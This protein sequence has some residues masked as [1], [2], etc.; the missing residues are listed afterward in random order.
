MFLA[1]Q[2]V[3]EG[4]LDGLGYRRGQSGVA[5]TPGLR[6]D[7]AP[8]GPV[9]HGLKHFLAL[10][11]PESGIGFGDRGPAPGGEDEV[12]HGTGERDRWISLRQRPQEGAD[13]TGRLGQAFPGAAEFHWYRHQGH[14]EIPQ[15]LIISRLTLR[16]LLTLLTFGGPQLG[17]LWCCFENL[18]NTQWLSHNR[19][20]GDDTLLRLKPRRFLGK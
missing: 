20:L 4:R 12:M 16:P 7:G 18:H 13:G 8:P 3:C 5:T 9:E 10:L 11:L 6:N 15:R 19:S 14:P 2:P 1:A 17:E